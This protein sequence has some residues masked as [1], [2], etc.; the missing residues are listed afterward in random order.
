MAIVQRRLIGVEA[1]AASAER[2][3]RAGLPA[4]LLAFAEEAV[5][6]IRPDWPVDSGR[7]RDSLRA[8]VRGGSVVVAVDV[9]YASYIHERGLSGP[10][11]IVRIADYIQ[12]HIDEIGARAVARLRGT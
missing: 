11:Y 2:D 1:W 5:K 4:L 7:S 6:D 10:S 9:S 12:Q 3:V 8:E